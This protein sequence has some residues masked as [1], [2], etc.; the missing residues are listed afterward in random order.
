[1]HLRETGPQYHSLKS[2]VAALRL[3]ESSGAGS[4][5]RAAACM[6]LSPSQPDAPQTLGTP[7]SIC[8]GPGANLLRRLRCKLHRLLASFG[9]CGVGVGA[10]LQ[11]QTVSRRL[12][13]RLAVLSSQRQHGMKER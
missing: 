3:G 5:S 7:K 4:S 1:M 12:G 13:P 6:S 2:R 8:L 10:L 9:L 11:L